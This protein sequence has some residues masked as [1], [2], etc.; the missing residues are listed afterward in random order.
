MKDSTSTETLTD[1]RHRCLRFAFLYFL[2]QSLPLSDE[3]FTLIVDRNW[4]DISY[5]DL[6]TLTRLTPKFVAGN[7]TFL[8]WLIIV[9]LALTGT[10]IWENSKWKY[11]DFDGLYYWLRV[12]VRYRLAIGILGF[13]FLK[14]FP[15]QAPYPSL[16]NLHTNYGD[17]SDW[18]MFSMSLGIVPAYESFLGAV[19]ILAGL[20]LLF[21]KTATLGATIV[22]IFTGNV[23]ISNL[24][25]DGGEYVY[26]FYLI[27]FA[28]FV[29]SFDAVRIFTLI[30]LNRPAQPNHFTL[31]LQGKM[32]IARLVSKGL[33]IFVFVFLYGI[34]A[35]SGFQ[36]DPYQ[37]PQKP[38]L[39]NASGL[40]NVR[41]FRING[42]TLPYSLTDSIRWRD[43]VFEKWA[44]LSVRSRRPVIIDSTNF[45]KINKNNFDRNYELSGI[46]SRHYYSYGIDP[47]NGTILLK[48]KNKNY[49]GDELQFRI[50]KPDSLT[51]I[52]TGSD[53][54]K[55]SLYVV[56]EKIQKKYPL[57]LGRRNPLTL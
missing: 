44:T 26:S 10:I 28:L 46:A 51:I 42:K 29:L 11:F 38:G 40:Y 57:Y 39:A 52:L 48:N 18:K 49:P 24:A 54:K 34:M 7:E 55:D 13:G 41:E 32:K 12:I 22:L 1:I 35:Y 17:L 37:F 53:Q 33:I 14:L 45:E 4:L 8:N 23:F 5:G 2:I 25:Y 21:R 16:S 31:R 20:L 47:S 27:S 6:F 30:S 19:E 9:I 43:V 3:F 15:M 56:L 36:N 50:S